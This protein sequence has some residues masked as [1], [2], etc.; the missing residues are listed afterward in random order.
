MNKITLEQINKLGNFLDGVEM[1]NEYELSYDTLKLKIKK[2][3]TKEDEYLI[4]DII[5][6]N[7]FIGMDYSPT[8]RECLTEIM[9][10][11]TFIVNGIDIPDDIE[12]VYAIYNTIKVLDMTGLIN[13]NCQEVYDRLN[14]NIDEKIEFHKRK[15]CAVLSQ[16]AS[17]VETFNNMNDFITSITNLTE[18]LTTILESGGN[19]ILKQITP[20]KING[21]IDEF[22]KESLKIVKDNL[23]EK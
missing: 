21:F 10:A 4:I 5:S 13:S 19:K 15:I 16:N 22:K 8:L 17:E 12:D 3:I 14:R 1:D 18:K 20:K 6:E 9:L 11:N 23:G 7:S 2:E